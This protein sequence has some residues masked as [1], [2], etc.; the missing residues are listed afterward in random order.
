[1]DSAGDG[2]RDG[3]AASTEWSMTDVVRATGTTSRTLR[4]YDQMGL[5]RPSRTGAGGLRFYDQQGLLRLQ[6][7]LVLRELGLGLPAI[8]AALDGGP[9]GI[10]D[11]VSAL[12]GHLV[13]LGKER[14]RLARQVAS[15]QHTITTL[16]RGEELM[17]TQMFDGFDHTQYREEVEQRWGTTAYADSDRWWRSLTAGDKEALGREHRDLVEGYGNASARGVDVGSEEVRAL[18]ARHYRWVRAGWGGSAPSAEAFVGLGEMYV[19]DPR[20][21][22]NYEVEGRNVAAYVRDAMAVYADREL[23]AEA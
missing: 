1:M 15:V 23:P 11:P 2:S 12:R 18:V 3:S 19:A 6:R 14:D 20:F 10:P 9:D 17:A 7:I 13:Q 8:T 21:A 16:E 22:S 4:H 5:L